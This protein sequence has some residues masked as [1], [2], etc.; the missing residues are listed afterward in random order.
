MKTAQDFIN[1]YNGK[2]VDY[3]HVYGPQCVDGFKVFCNWIGA[4][5]LTTRTGWADGYWYYN[6]EYA[7]YVKF[8]LDPAKLKKG[9]WLFW[10]KGSRSCKSSHVGMFVS[11]A[12][13]NHGMIFGENQG[14][15]GGFTTVKIGLDILGAFRFNA[16]QE[17]IPMW[18][19]NSK[20]WWYEH[21]DGSYTRNNWEQIDD[22]WYHF[23]K[24]GYMQTG[25]IYVGNKWYYLKDDGVMAT[26][27]ISDKGKWYYLNDSGAMMTGW[28]QDKGK[29]YYLGRDGAMFVGKHTCPCYFDKS[30]ALIRK[31]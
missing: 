3:D 30:G 15:N 27:W 4:P 11:Y 16:L 24:N 21:A 22:K 6:G 18:K 5:V 31:E 26:G 20:G 2:V 9:D 1:Q 19:K 29:W 12:D 23:D 25:W 10:A 7:A 17:G 13:A 14:G 8:I 28:I